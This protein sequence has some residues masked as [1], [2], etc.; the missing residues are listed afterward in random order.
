MVAKPGDLYDRDL[1]WDDLERFV[2]SSR[3]GLRLGVLYGRRRV[4]KSF[5]LRRLVREHGGT[6]HMALEEEPH[7]ALARFAATVAGRA[8]LAAGQLHFDDWATA[9]RFA[10]EGPQIAGGSHAQGA[11]PRPRLLVIDEL[12]FLL[13]HPEG[14]VVPSAI[15]QLVDESR[16]RPE[17]VPQRII[18][19][20]SALSVM[21]ELLSGGKPLR[22]R[23]E[24]DMQ[25]RPFDFRTF[26][27]LYG[28]EDPTV[29]FRLYAI[30]GG[31]PGYRDL[32][33]EVSPQTDAELDDLVLATL[34]NP[35]HAMFGE[36]GYLLREDPRI[37]DRA[38]YY[39][40]LAAVADGASTPSAVAVRLGRDARSLAHPLGVLTAAGFVR[41]HEDMLLA[42]RPA[43][44]VADPVVRFDQVVV[45][46]RLAAF[47]DRRARP[48]WRG[49]QETMRARVYGP[50]FEALAREWTRS[51]AA[52]E[53]LGGEVGEVGGTVV[54]DHAGRAQHEVDVVAL[55]AG[56]RPGQRDVSILAIGEAKD[57]DR[58]RPVADVARLERIRA[59]LVARGVGAEGAKL[60]VFGRSGF[61]PELAG[62]AAGRSDVEL[63]D[64]DRI[65]A[66]Y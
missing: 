25:L 58:S 56:S 32:L 49:A 19:C 61:D 42:R 28:I 63:V 52:V 7:P 3:P 11:H 47:E 57:S 13:A 66:G 21:S 41:K 10:L 14:R 15:Q 54:N 8:G 31:T 51:H 48:A 62:L 17:A 55:T 64:I 34:L 29:A 59:L 38:L 23:A 43:L 33:G 1:E 22:G 2:S 18:V 45:A 50:A 46:P 65:R 9:L 40:V 12:P 37:T 26:A 35:S 4:G 20:G 30:V 44:R 36:A 6:Y 60:L 27:G 16:S 5:L 39:S 24:L 53:T